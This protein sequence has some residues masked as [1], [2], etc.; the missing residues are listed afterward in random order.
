[1]WHLGDYESALIEKYYVN[2]AVAYDENYL[3]DRFLKMI[4]G[5]EYCGYLCIVCKKAELPGMV[6]ANIE[7][8]KQN[9]L[10]DDMK[11]ILLEGDFILKEHDSEKMCRFGE[12]RQC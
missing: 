11:R 5:V 12:L 6:L 2:A 8:I 9:N 4:I 1:M 3:M 7:F 10:P